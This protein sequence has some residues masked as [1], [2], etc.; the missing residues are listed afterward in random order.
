MP[1]PD[2]KK[3]WA[4][5][6]G[7]S[8]GRLTPSEKKLHDGIFRNRGRKK[9][10]SR[11]LQRKVGGR[12]RSFRRV[13]PTEYDEVGVT[14]AH[15]K[16]RKTRAYPEPEGWFHVRK[17]PSKK[18]ELYDAF[19][20]RHDALALAGDLNR[21]G[22]DV[23]Y[24]QKIEPQGGDGGRLKWGVFY[25]HP[26]KNPA[27]SGAYKIVEVGGLD[28]TTGIRPPK[29]HFSS[30]NAAYKYGVMKW[31]SAS[32]H[33]PGGWQVIQVGGKYDKNSRARMKRVNPVYD[34]M[35]V[36]D[37]AAFVNGRLR[38]GMHPAEI[39]E[40]L[41]SQGLAPKLIDVVFM[42]ASPSA[43]K[44]G[45]FDRAYKVAR[46]SG[47]G[48]LDAL[49]KAKRKNPAPYSR[50]RKTYQGALFHR[51]QLQEAARRILGTTDV[52]GLR[53]NARKNRSVE[54]GRRRARFVATSPARRRAVSSNKCIVV[55]NGKRYLASKS[56]LAALVKKGFCVKSRREIKNNPRYIGG[57]GKLLAVEYRGTDTAHYRHDFKEPKPFVVKQGH[58]IAAKVAHSKDRGLL[59]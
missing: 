48:P 58:L 2:M 28:W 5:I 4:A 19:T 39:Q 31:G 50:S 45:Q 9:K 49:Q 42:Y 14:R 37:L 26:R 16:A 35:L 7:E 22:K 54:K 23:F 24:V 46:R 6:R 32:Y 38:A 3:V 8:V 52:P 57:R 30:Y 13:G 12:M 15:F 25:Q 17:N 44:E 36:R 27:K 43:I 21:Q 1:T 55:V 53:K 18:G 11:T 29:K 41:R 59:G 20:N 51:A 56:E 34:P 40:M 33:A 10:G 47:L